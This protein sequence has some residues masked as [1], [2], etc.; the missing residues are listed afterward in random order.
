MTGPELQLRE[1][2]EALQNESCH[3]GSIPIPDYEPGVLSIICPR[4][5][6]QT[7]APDFDPAEALKRWIAKLNQ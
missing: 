2:A 7:C 4:C 1:L 5:N 6:F 3:C